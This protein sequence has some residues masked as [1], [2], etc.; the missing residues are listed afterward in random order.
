MKIQETHIQQQKKLHTYEQRASAQKKNT[1]T[2]THTHTHTHI[3]RAREKKEEIAHTHTRTH[4][5]T[6]R[7]SHTE[8]MSL[9]SHS[10]GELKKPK[11]G[12]R[13]SNQSS[14]CSFC[15][16]EFKPSP[17]DRAPGAAHFHQ[18]KIIT[19]IIKKKIFKK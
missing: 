8:G 11:I 9:H 10:W 5:R 3:H 4:T 13:D 2:Y 18:K 12:I 15:V 19:N 1:E 14:E 6:P 16:I 7:R 17:I